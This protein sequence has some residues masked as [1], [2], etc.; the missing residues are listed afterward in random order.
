MSDAFTSGRTDVALVRIIA[1]IDFR[2]PQGEANA[3]A[4]ARPFGA[5]VLPELQA[6]LF[7]E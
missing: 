3:L 6:R 4:I 1:P 7:R 2:H 5:Q